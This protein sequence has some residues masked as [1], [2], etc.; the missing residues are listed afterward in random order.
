MERKLSNEKRNIPMFVYYLLLM[1]IFTAVFF[2]VS[3]DIS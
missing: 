1:L 2:G 3:V